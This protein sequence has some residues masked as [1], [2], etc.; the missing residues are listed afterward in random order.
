V[1]IPRKP[2]PNGLLV[3]L[4]VTCIEHPIKSDHVL[5]FIIGI[6][7]HLWQGDSAP[8]DAIQTFMKQYVIYYESFLYMGRW[9][10]NKKSFI[11]ADSAFGLLQLLKE[12]D[13][14]GGFTTF[15]TSKQANTSL[16]SLLSSHLLPNY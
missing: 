2:H 5:P 13:E 3:Y 10:H 4:L 9:T 16:W 11:V 12:I 7:P 14:W 15:A 8:Q 1:Y 6:K